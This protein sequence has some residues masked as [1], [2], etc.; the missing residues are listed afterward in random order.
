MTKTLFGAIAIGMLGLTVSDVVPAAADPL[1]YGPETCINGYVWRAA[2]PGD[3]VCV[4]PAVRD[5]TAQQ[6][7]VAAQNVQPNDGNICK[8][9]FVWRNAY[10]GDAA[11]VTP[12]V[13]DQAAADNAASPSRKAAGQAQQGPIAPVGVMLSVTGT[14]TAS[15]IDTYDPKAEPR[16]H[17][18]ALPFSSTVAVSPKSGD[19]FELV[20]VGKGD[21]RPG[22]TISVNGN[23][24]AQQ[25]VGGSGQCTYNVP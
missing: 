20:V 6:N 9:G 17:D 18:V 15:T 10:P 12:D 5:A 16:L 25:P 3:A 1:P 22:C 8:S 21:S 24:V 11:C 2:R 13:R 14:G 19:L 4:T 23:V 7:A